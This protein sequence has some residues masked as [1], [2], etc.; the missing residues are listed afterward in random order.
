MARFV[1]VRDPLGA[2][3]AALGR[4]NGHREGVKGGVVLGSLGPGDR[5]LATSL[6]G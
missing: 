1:P 6:G 4:A 2:T 3:L 5:W